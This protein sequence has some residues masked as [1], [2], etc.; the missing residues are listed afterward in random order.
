M[1]R[2]SSHVL[3]FWIPMNTWFLVLEMKSAFARQLPIKGNRKKNC[4]HRTSIRK[5][6]P[7]NRVANGSTRPTLR[8][9]Y[10]QVTHERKG[11]CSGTVIVKECV[12]RLKWIYQMCCDI[13]SMETYSVRRLECLVWLIMVI[14]TNTV[15]YSRR[16]RRYFY[17]NCRCIRLSTPNISSLITEHA[18]QCYF[19]VLL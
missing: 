13:D 8:P 16:I 2:K 1:R 3:G 17:D 18:D 12:Q 9:L 15:I 11:K 7:S 4:T 5:H 6:N 10:W 19:R 14:Q